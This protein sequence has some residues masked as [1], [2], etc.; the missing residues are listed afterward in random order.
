MNLGDIL[1]QKGGDTIT[2]GAGTRVEEAIRLMSESRVGSVMVVAPDG[3]ALG[4]FTERD[5]LN[6]LAARGES[7]GAVPVEDVMTRKLVVAEPD[8]KID[9][10][11]AA[12]TENRCRHMPVLQEGKVLGVI[13]IGD[14]VKA[15]LE[16]TEFE[17]E[18]LREYISSGY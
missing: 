6:L 2:V 17:V 14:L 11:L 1:K 16:E 5:V 4:I 9:D 13:S 8:T 15:K 10:T 18:S 12:M 7:A 3:E